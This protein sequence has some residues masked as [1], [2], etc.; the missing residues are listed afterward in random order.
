MTAHG[1][2]LLIHLISMNGIMKKT[3]MI[4]ALFQAQ[5]AI[6]R[7][8]GNV[9]MVIHHINPIHIIGLSDTPDVQNAQTKKPIESSGQELET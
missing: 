6:L 1:K 5:K 9:Q 8:S 3:N 2:A 4:L 7:S